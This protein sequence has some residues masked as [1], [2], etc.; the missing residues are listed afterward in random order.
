MKLLASLTNRIFLASAMLAVFCIAFAVYLVNV[1]VTRDAEAELERGLR[2]A[3][4]LVEQ[5]RATLGETFTL[6]ARLVADLPKLKA[7]AATADPPTVQ[8]LAA[9]Y[10]AQVRSALFL[11]TDR[12]GRV[13]A[14]IGS[15][16]D[17]GAPPDVAA[18]LAGRES[19]TFRPHAHGVLEVV[20][21]PITIGAAPPE[22][23]GT[24]SIGFLLDDRLAARF[25]AL[26]MSEIAFAL[27]GRILASTLP[28]SQ[29]S[30]LAALLSEP[31]ISQVN[32]GGSDYVA[33]AQ[34]LVPGAGS[35]APVALVLRSRTERLRFLHGI[36]TALAATAVLAVLLAV[37][38]SYGVARTVTR[39]LAAITDAMREMAGTGDLTRKITPSAGRW[40]DED[41]RLLA[42]TFNTLTDSIARFQR[43]AAQRDRLSAL[44]RLA[45][46]V[47]HE[48]RNP[49]MIIKA[50]L[51][52]LRRED[53]PQDQRE[54]VGDIDGEV[55]RLNRIVNE[56]LDYARP[57]RLDVAPTDLNAV[58]AN[59]AAAAVTGEP[60]PRIALALD[61]TLPAVVTDGERLR[62]VLVNI[63][64]NARQAVAARPEGTA[65]GKPVELRTA[66]SDGRVAIVVV[67]RGVGIEPQDLAHVFDPYFTTRRTG[68]GLGLAIAKNIVEALG[69][70]IAV[71]SKPQEG[72]E[73]RIELPTTGK[74]TS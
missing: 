73:V 15:S 47:A 37:L 31:G 61:P 57:I 9:E 24:L 71:R 58:C 6:V 32:L 23:L 14:A 22:I 66:R 1:R 2:E 56:V 5:H 10:H 43:D 63:L 60:E 40:G 65:E 28:P 51:R 11:V 39:P 69:G 64:T 67:D 17:Q 44:G 20:T 35:R 49:L 74:P 34:P 50:S 53:A 30:H 62:N 48:I 42:T 27:D 70:A 41:A 12:T 29:Q 54:A 26:T 68:T 33:L 19:A 72:T 16:P 52:P 38:L 59:A 36:H 18:A 46:V 25:G 21:V 8:P 7:A 13:L 4:N 45:T 3:A 55:V